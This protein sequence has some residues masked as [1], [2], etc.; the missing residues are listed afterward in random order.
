MHSVILQRLQSFTFHLQHVFLL[1]L[2][3]YDPL[4]INNASPSLQS[5]LLGLMQ[6]LHIFVIQNCSSNRLISPLFLSY[7]SYLFF[8]SIN[9]PLP[10][11]AAFNTEIS[12]DEHSAQHLSWLQILQTVNKHKQESGD[13]LKTDNLLWNKILLAW[14]DEWLLIPVKNLL[15][16]S[17]SS[18]WRDSSQNPVSWYAM[19][20][21]V[22]QCST[23]LQ[24]TL[25]YSKIYH[26]L[27]SV[28][29]PA[30]AV[31]AA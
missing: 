7:I 15:S 31:Y 24:Q 19:N 23:S 29:A 3:A 2:R 20:T 26:L 4:L 17:K 11:R 13:I 16:T 5:V 10:E 28:R 14:L 25:F 6:G 9:F 21:V 30:S 22:L 8:S 1:L 12:T 18:F 27:Q